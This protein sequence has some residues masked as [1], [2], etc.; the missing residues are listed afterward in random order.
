M[1]KILNC[2][3]LLTFIITVLVPVT[4]IRIHKLAS[5]LFLL[6][7]IVHTLI[8]RKHLHAK[9]W[10]LLLLVFSSFLTGLLGLIFEQY[11]IVLIFHRVI[12]IAVVFCMAI[13][14][15]AFH[16]KFRQ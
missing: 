14:I 4:G 7:C 3:L 1:K 8:H 10:L 16:K 13:H 15:F 6:L 2:L 12:S 5:T 11:P 9:K